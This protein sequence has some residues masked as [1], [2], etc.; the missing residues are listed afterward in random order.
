M[1]QN[2]RKALGYLLAVMLLAS[3]VTTL[4]AEAARAPAKAK[5]NSNG[6]KVGNKG[7]QGK[8]TPPNNVRKGDNRDDAKSGKIDRPGDGNSGQGDDKKG[9]FKDPKN[10]NKRPRHDP[11][12]CPICKRHLPPQKEPTKR[13]PP[14]TTDKDNQG[15]RDRGQGEGREGAGQGAE[16]RRPDF[17]GRKWDKREDVRDRREDR[18]DKKEDIKDR[19]E[20]RRDRREDVQ[21]KREDRR[22]QREDVKDRREDKRDNKYPPRRKWGAGDNR[23]DNKSGKIDR[24]GDGNSG[25][26]NDRKLPPK[27]EGADRPKMQPRPEGNS[28]ANTTDKRRG[29]NRDDSKSGKIDRI[30]DGNSGQ[31]NDKGARL[32]PPHN[33]R[34]CP[35]CNPK[36]RNDAKKTQNAQR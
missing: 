6:P 4:Y 14:Q 21:D 16:N 1:W 34:T 13:Q 36:L 7:T 17:P 28:S 22:D 27:R 33:P 10:D 30:G 18:R 31:G 9:G 8:N 29:D 12:T 3:L 24:I 32:R 5:G 26:G 23:D 20:D 25:Q 35:I 11:R 15:V 19:R 2:I